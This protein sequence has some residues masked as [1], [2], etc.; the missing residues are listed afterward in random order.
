MVGSSRT[1]NTDE[2][3]LG[4]PKALP[5]S[6]P[7]R[8]SVICGWRSV[9]DTCLSVSTCA[10]GDSHGATRTHATSANPPLPL[11]APLIHT[12]L[13]AAHPCLAIRVFISPPLLPVSARLRVRRRHLIGSQ[14]RTQSRTHVPA[15]VF[16]RVCTGVW[17]VCLRVCVGRR[18]T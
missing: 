11:T 2:P 8:A 7:C 17:D 9:G 5:S 16:R 4:R 15:D 3:G 18:R 14:T 12:P 6:A 1:W 10:S 13:S